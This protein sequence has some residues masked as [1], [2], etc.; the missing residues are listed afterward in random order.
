MSEDDHRPKQRTQ[1]TMTATPT[2]MMSR[3][4]SYCLLLLVAYYIRSSSSSSSSNRRAASL[5][6]PQSRRL[7]DNNNNNAAAVNNNNNNAYD[8]DNVYFQYDLSEFSVRF[9]KCQYV[10]MFDDELLQ[11]QQQD[12]DDDDSS[13]LVSPLA[14]KHFVIYRLCPTETCSESCGGSS[15]SGSSQSS[16][17]S[18]S[19]SV[20]Y[21]QYVTDVESYLKFTVENQ[22]EYLESMCK[23]C[24][25]K[26]GDNNDN[27]EEAGDNANN[28]NNNNAGIDC[29]CSK[30]CD[31]Y[32]NLEEYGYV[33]ASQYLECQQFQNNNNNNNNNGEDEN[34][35]NDNN[36]EDNNN[37]DNSIYIGPRC[38]VSGDAIS[39]GLFYDEDCWDP[40]EDQNV[41]DV[42]GAKLSY[43]LLAQSYY[44]N[45]RV[46]LTCQ[47]LN[48]DEDEDDNNENAEGE[49]EEQDA[50]DVDEDNV[51]QMCEDLYKSAAKCESRSGLTNGFI[52][53][54]REDGD[55][56][57]QVENEF[58]SCNFIDSLVWNSYTETGEINVGAPQDEIIRYVTRKQTIALSFLG[59]FILCLIGTMEYFRRKIEVTS[60]RL[61]LT[62][63]SSTSV[64]T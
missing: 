45:E 44:A 47:E 11:Q 33:D 27:E 16:S 8:D 64:F 7:E 22:Q 55:Y 57:N 19:S 25:N 30:L 62:E 50:D 34:E 60:R 15:S 38:D 46:C 48:D 58:M 20:V 51:N 39:I 49:N 17:S 21:G 2:R 14:L 28:N 41:E 5:L 56:E 63:P 23:K 35:N 31:R 1:D 53:T 6:P 24:E 10:K 37:N 29:S 3:V 12:D 18:S 42:L 61:Q 26:C 43:H 54:N 36:G 32:E 52:Q 13:S 4:P 9:E 40:I 59:T